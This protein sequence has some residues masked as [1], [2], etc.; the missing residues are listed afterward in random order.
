MMIKIEDLKHMQD[1]FTV[2]D[3]E[4]KT[5]V[6]VLTKMAMIDALVETLVQEDET[7]MYV[8]NSI[9]KEVKAKVAAVALYTNI[10]L[11][12]NDY[13]NYDIIK[14]TRLLEQL[15]DMI[16]DNYYSE[17][18]DIEVF[19][20]ML[21]RRIDDK[22]AENSMNRILAIRSKE[23]IDA[24]QRTMS[25]VDAML[26]KGDPNTIAKHLSKG[27]EMI[28]KKLPDF[29]KFDIEQTAKNFKVK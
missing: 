15:M 27:V 6:S 4:V 7:G 24:I 13:L 3:L 22:L 8:V 1:L 9:D 23:V 11:T 25:H 16:Q 5:Y 26:D 17:L 21:D 2:G 20:D 29:S 19:Y 10:E 18:N 12:D 14:S 28:A